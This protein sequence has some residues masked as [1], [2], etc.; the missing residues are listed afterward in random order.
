M[1][2]PSDK[3]ACRSDCPGCG[4]AE[5]PSG[6]AA[7]SGWRLAGFSA[8]VFLLPLVLAAAGAALAGGRPVWQLVGALAGLAVG[9][10]VARAV[11]RRPR[12]VEA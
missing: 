7:H 6:A 1:N 8:L 3:N 11:L 2:S 12:E 4:Q 10:A 9:V 5:R